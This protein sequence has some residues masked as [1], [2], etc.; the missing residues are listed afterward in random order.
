MA[1]PAARVV[2][3]FGRAALVLL[4]GLGV[5]ELAG[6]RGRTS[7]D[8]TAPHRV[9]SVAT[10]PH[11]IVSLVPATTEM[12]FAMHA[13]DRVVAVSNYD[14][15]PPDVE[16]LPRVGGL[17]DPYVEPLLALK[18]DLVIVYGTQ[19]EL[20]ARLASVGIPMFSYTHQELR[21]IT[22][23][24]RQIGERI[25]LGDDA[26]AAARE[27]EQKLDL[28]RAKVAARPHP[29]SLLVFGREAGTLRHIE[30][31][32][33]Y[34]FLHDLLE[35]AGATDVLADIHHP[36]V[37]MSTEMILARQPE[38]LIE[39]Q[40]GSSIRADNLETERAVW[41]GLPSL[42]AVKNKRVHLLV[43]NEFVVPGPRVVLA[44]ERLARTLHPEAF[45]P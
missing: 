33:G 23:T 31:S 7:A 40:Y 29:R 25:G 39:L 9:T 12:L 43:G 32:G 13:G 26:D 30:A 2:R 20:K 38:V 5:L 41:N 19:D 8:D 17:L 15:Y 16:R 42:P 14:T 36:K 28:I 34:G 6:C 45:E 1:A 37:D 21:D 18:P 4:C 35:L 44:A 24:M 10:T 11:R 27:V 22:A 3:S